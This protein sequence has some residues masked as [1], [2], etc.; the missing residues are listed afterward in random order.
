[1]KTAKEEGV[2]GLPSL[3]LMKTV[4]E[5]GGEDL[6]SPTLM[7]TA[8]EEGEAKLDLIDRLR[9]VLTVLDGGLLKLLN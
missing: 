3:T 4:K 2:A 1:M 6:P 8:K 5:E 9:R 7:K